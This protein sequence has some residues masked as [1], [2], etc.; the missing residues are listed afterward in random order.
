MSG[1]FR[2]RSFVRVLVAVFFTMSGALCMGADRRSTAELAA[3]LPHLEET[4]RAG[5]KRAYHRE[6]ATLANE[7]AVHS[8]SSDRYRLAAALLEN[9]VS[10]GTAAL[11]N[12]MQAMK[13]AASCVLSNRN[14][15]IDTRRANIRVLSRFLGEVRKETIQNYTLRPTT[16]NVAPPPNLPFGFAGMDPKQIHDPVARAQYEAS[17]RQNQENGSNELAAIHFADAEREMAEPIVAYMIETFRAEDKASPL[18]ADCIKSIGLPARKRRRWRVRLA[19]PVAGESVPQGDVSLVSARRLRR[20]C[21]A[22]V[23]RPCHF[24]V[25]DLI[26]RRNGSCD[27]LVQGIPLD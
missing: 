18:V 23:C 5:N 8:P 9:I 3:S 24:V 22:A 26:G 2:P 7:I 19:P 13:A 12:D 1:H 27:W 21:Q 16:Y 4:W 11:D 6:A 15:S 20:H 10:K 14:A 25:R 17:I